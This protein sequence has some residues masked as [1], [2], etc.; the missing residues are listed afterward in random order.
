MRLFKGLPFILLLLLV[1]FLPATLVSAGQLSPGLM[2]M[3]DDAPADKPVSVLVHFTDRLDIQDLSARLSHQKATRQQRHA[4]IVFSL[5][6][7]ARVQDD[8][9]LELDS[10]VA[11]GSVLGYTQY[12]ITNVMVVYAL[13]D[14]IHRIALRTDVDY[15][16]PNFQA[17]LIDPVDIRS[18]PAGSEMDTR[19][20]GM[21]PGIDA[22]RAPE[23]WNVLGINGTG[24]IIGSLDTGVDGN[25]P[26]LAD[27][28]RG[29]FADASECWMDVIG[30]GA[31]FPSDGHG[32]GTHT[33]GTMAGIAPDD[34][35]GIAPGA[36]WIAANAIDQ[37]ANP[38]FDND[39]IN[40]FQWFADPDG[41]PETIED[42][43]DVVQNS[44]GV[45][46]NFTGYF[47]CDERWWDAIDNCE[48]AGVVV[49][50]SA[51][52]EGPSAGTLRSPADRASTIYN[53]FSVGSTQYYAPYSISSFSSRGPT[54]CGYVD[55]AVAIKPEVSAPG[56][57]IYSAEPGG[58]YQ[59]MSGTSMAGPHVSG[60]VALMRQANP[61]LEVDIIKQILMDTA[62]DLGT[63]GEDNNYGWGII[64]AYAAVEACMTGFGSLTGQ[65]TNASFGNLPLAGAHVAV[66]GWGSGLNT[67]ANG[68]YTTSLPAGEYTV[69]VTMPGFETVQV[70]NVMIV[71]DSQTTQSFALMD[72]AGPDL[73]E[74][75]G[76]LA[77]SDVTGPYTMGLQA[78][79]F[80]TVSEL[81]LHWKVAGASWND[82]PM[83]LVRG[84]YTGDIPGHPAN[85]EIMYYFS[86]TDGTG[87]TSQ[88]PEGAPDETFPLLITEVI[89]LTEAEDPGD[90]DW[91]LGA[92]DDQ[93]TSGLWI[94]ADPVGTE[95]NGL[96]VQPEN[97]HT[98]DPAVAC[99]VTGNANPGDGAGVGDVDD[100]CTTLLTPVFDLSG[101]DRAVVKYWCWYGEGGYS[102][103]DDFVVEVSNNNGA[104]WVEFD[105]IVDN[106]NTW[107]QVSVELNTL[108]DG[109]FELTDQIV[110]RFLAC[111]FNEG[112][113]IEAAIDDF[114][115]ESF[116]SSGLSPV[117]DIPAVDRPVMLR[118]NHP[119][120]FNPT[121]AIGFS[122]PQA[123]QTELMVYTIDGRRVA[124]LVSEV[125]AAGE[126]HVSWN[127]QDDNG[128]QVASGAYFYRLKAGN[129]L[130]VKRMILVK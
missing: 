106:A 11:S 118:Q 116:T 104:S 84:A 89:Y 6:D 14:E 74:P 37:G 96:N 16:E 103:D 47:D 79:D 30:S 88:L 73:S 129:D 41:N 36:L 95:Y 78:N 26:A 27:R 67:N 28:W 102:L 43:P 94:R 71:E 49:V 8:L 29:N 12:W 53:G 3:L 109:T 65:V 31:A 39:I 112:G 70:N 64:D 117:D 13:P 111:D 86:A 83:S 98:A 72:I 7:A 114:A 57:D 51:G 97:D 4:E 127:G 24:S 2:A 81:T 125:M 50:F 92:D 85:T 23:T 52:N 99:F 10:A 108:E 91:Q 42:V 63:A 17:E 105:R 115:I 119:N 18:A 120:P 34:T 101:V 9:A 1:Q 61:D 20:I 82:V 107:N 123:V 124:T 21:A 126:H 25:H 66:Q 46:E 32:H 69:V 87:L 80:S 122:L 48:A 121:T 33:T 35:I 40:C 19:G 44:W 110:L 22:V 130:L 59:Y 100:G 76:E 55:P 60:V 90:P 62:V 56:S 15:V 58:G 54:T 5:K 77:T 93:A 75:T 113:L 68:E 38:G 45:N 128:R